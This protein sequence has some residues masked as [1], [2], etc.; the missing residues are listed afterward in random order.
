[1][2]TG[3]V[4]DPETNGRLIFVWFRVPD[5]NISSQHEQPKDF[6]N[7]PVEAHT[8]QHPLK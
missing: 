3:L 8:V 1:M 5:L 6:I 2:I 7:I 4:P